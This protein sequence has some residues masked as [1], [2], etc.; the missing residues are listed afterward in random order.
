MMQ[1]I[2]SITASTKSEYA[3]HDI[4]YNYNN[5]KESFVK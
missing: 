5:L 3:K 4:A 2:T 1:L